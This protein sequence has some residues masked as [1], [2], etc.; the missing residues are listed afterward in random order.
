MVPAPSVRRPVQFPDDDNPVD[1]LVV[2]LICAAVALPFSLFLSRAFGAS[3]G[4]ESPEL[5]LSWPGNYKLV[6]GRQT[7]HFAESRR[8]L[9]I[10]SNR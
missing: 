8:V 2:G 4:P 5:Q 6:L 1:K 10:Q 7:W 3:S 9:P